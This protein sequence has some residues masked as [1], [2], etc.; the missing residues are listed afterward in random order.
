MKT[1]RRLFHKNKAHK[2]SGTMALQITSMADI[3]TILLVFLLKGIASDALTIN[4][5]NATRLPAGINTTSLTEGALQV[6]LSSNGV[7]VDKEFI[8]AYDGF[9][10][11]LNERLVRERARQKAISEA[12]DSV[13]NDGRVIVLSDQKVPFSSIKVALRVL[14]QNGYGEVKFGVIKE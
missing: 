4:P 6:E 11:P 7:L 12:N 14:S 9:E 2:E 13:K 1:K 8:S 5:S 3:F 10:K